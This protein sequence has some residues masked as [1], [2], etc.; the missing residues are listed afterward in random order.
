[1]D[2]HYVGKRDLGF[3]IS[4]ATVLLLM[5]S[6]IFFSNGSSA[7]CLAG[8]FVTENATFADSN[9]STIQLKGI[10]FMLIEQTIKQDG[11]MFP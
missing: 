9:H 1:M 2:F 4:S 10:M 11:E 5:S 6:D 8:N 3:S 7:S